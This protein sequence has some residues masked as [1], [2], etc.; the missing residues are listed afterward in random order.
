MPSPDSVC[1]SAKR[2]FSLT[3]SF[4]PFSQS[5]LFYVD[6]SNIL[7]EAISVDNG[8]TWRTGPLG[9]GKFRVANHSKTALT[10]C[11]LENSSSEDGEEPV[12]GTGL[13]LW[14]GAEDDSA[15]ELS[16]AIG[17]RWW[18]TTFVFSKLSAGNPL[19]SSC[20]S[21]GYA[22]L[23]TTTDDN[24]DLALWW[25]DFGSSN[26]NGSEAGNWTQG[27]FPL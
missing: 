18:R 24:D 5:H 9:D 8:T 11:N 26:N 4:F 23:W 6:S 21:G 20:D 1:L 3:V 12:A 27:L 22:Y 10:A 16:W 15:Q 13:K 14:Y 19:A 17:D 2:W 7:Q 25:K